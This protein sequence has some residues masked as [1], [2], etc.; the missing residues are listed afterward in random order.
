MRVTMSFAVAASNA[1]G[2]DYDAVFAR[3]ERALYQ[4]KNSSRDRV[5]SSG[6]LA[7]R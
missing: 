5:C 6:S 7:R 1:R 4:A 3:A 2:F